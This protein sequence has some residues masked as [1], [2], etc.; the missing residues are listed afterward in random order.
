MIRYLRMLLRFLQPEDTRMEQEKDIWR[1]ENLDI[2]I[3]E[4]PIYKTETLNFIAE[5]RYCR[6]VCE[7]A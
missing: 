4:N 5:I 7:S 6:L 3:E 1:L 2:P